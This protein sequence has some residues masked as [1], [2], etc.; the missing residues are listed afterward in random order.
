M[1]A[2]DLISALLRRWYVVLV[3]AALT[4][5]TG[6]MLLRSTPVYFCEFDVTVLPP[7]E[8]TSQNNLRGNSYGLVP[9]AGLLV[10]EFNNG[11]HPLDMGTKNTTLFGERQFEGYRVRLQNEGDQWGRQ[12]PRPVIDVQVVDPDPE[13][14]VTLSR[15]IVAELDEILSRRQDTLTPPAAV[16]MS[17]VT[18]PPDPIVFEVT[19]SKPRAAGGLLLFGGILTLLTVM[20]LERRWPRRPTAPPVS[21]PSGTRAEVALVG[22]SLGAIT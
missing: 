5:A 3:G 7:Q 1:T 9:M 12:Y 14:V 8:A 22:R 15:S 10:T 13:R 4:V 19:G 18:S 17:L 6:L 11:K 2:R 16:R 21:A 20:T